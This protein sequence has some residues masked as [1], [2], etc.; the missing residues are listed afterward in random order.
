MYFKGIVKKDVKTKN[1]IE[2]LNPG[3]IALINHKDLDEIAAMS[4]VEKKVKCIIN[5]NKTISGRYPNQG[6]SVLVDANIPILKVMKVY[7]I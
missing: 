4:L 3:E 7:L 2:R 5:V 6:P 1:L